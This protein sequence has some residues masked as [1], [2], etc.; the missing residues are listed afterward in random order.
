MRSEH[1]SVARLRLEPHT[2]RRHQLRVHTA[3]AGF[4]IAGDTLYMEPPPCTEPL[5]SNGTG[6]SPLA[7]VC[8]TPLGGIAAPQLATSSDDIL[9]GSPAAAPSSASPARVASGLAGGTA[10]LHLHASELSFSHPSTG[11]WVTYRSE[12]Q[13]AL[14]D[15]WKSQCLAVG[16]TP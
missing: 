15:A 4:A 9:G 7:S 5:A 3:A 16:L 8:L 10:R 1:G 2:G 13:F 12:P 14:K 6:Q 11:E